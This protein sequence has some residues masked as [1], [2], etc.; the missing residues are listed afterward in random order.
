M[1]FESADALAKTYARNK[2]K[3]YA[4]NKKT[5]ARN[6]KLLSLRSITNGL[7]QT[8]IAGSPRFGALRSAAE[9]TAVGLASPALLQRT[10]TAVAPTQPGATGQ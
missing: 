6:K 2:K 4:R 1:A 9:R 5:Y 8:R 10:Q 7:Q 3:T